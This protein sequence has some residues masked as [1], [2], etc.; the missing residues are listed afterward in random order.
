M[1]SPSGY[2]R[3]LQSALQS[4]VYGRPVA[5]FL[6][7]SYG[8]Q[9]ANNLKPHD[10]YPM[11]GIY[12]SGM[13]TSDSKFTGPPNVVPMSADTSSSD[14]DSFD[15]VGQGHTRS[16]PEP[17]SFGRM[18]LADIS[19]TMKY[20]NDATR[21]YDGTNDMDDQNGI[22]DS[23]YRNAQDQQNAFSEGAGQRQSSNPFGECEY[24]S[25]MEHLKV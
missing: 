25:T 21:G 24:S 11:L 9:S 8:E 10:K 22:D 3:D 20:D 1:M 12:E 2:P 16:F 5:S 15:E 6:G 4:G 17:R 18:E 13:R 14:D 7:D 19:Q 23:F